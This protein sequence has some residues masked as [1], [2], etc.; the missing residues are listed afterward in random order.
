MLSTLGFGAGVI[1]GLIGGLFMSSEIRA[2][3]E[4]EWEIENARARAE[5]RE[6]GGQEVEA[7]GEVG[8][9]TDRRRSRER[10]GGFVADSGGMEQG[11]NSDAF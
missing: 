1:D 6:S 2:L 3:K 5:E 4:F 8:D 11:N 7:K 9:R 10:H